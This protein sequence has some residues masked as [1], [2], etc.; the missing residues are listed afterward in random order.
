V[1]APRL[2]LRSIKQ[3]LLHWPLQILGGALIAVSALVVYYTFESSQ[4]V[5]VQYATES[6][7]EH[8]ES[9]TQFRNFYAQELVPRAMRAGVSVTH[10]YKSK[11]NALPL[12]ATLAIDLGHY[13]CGCTATCPFLG[14]QVSAS[15]I[16]FKSKR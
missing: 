8:A 4:R 3:V 9:V 7:R 15:W 5:V 10:D 1:Q 14:A 2:F 6:A 13:R 11:D 16:T 12:P